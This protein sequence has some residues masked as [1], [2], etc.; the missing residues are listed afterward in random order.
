MQL[1]YDLQFH[2][3]LTLGQGAVCSL[4]VRIIR[5]LHAT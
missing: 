1:Q 5:V 4:Q 3:P 2:S